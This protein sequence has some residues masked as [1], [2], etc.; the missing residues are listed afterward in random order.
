V[1][2]GGGSAITTGSNPPSD[3]D[4]AHG[5]Q[6]IRPW[7]SRPA[8]STIEAVPPVSNR[9]SLTFLGG[10]G[11]VT[12]SRF[13]V[14]S[15]AAKVLIDCGLYQGVKELRLRNWAPFPVAPSTLDAVVLTHAHVDHSGYLPRLVADGFD[16]PVYATPGTTELARIVL[17]DSGHL[18][19][20]DAAFANRRGFSKHRPP[21]PLFTEAD[22]RT[23]CGLLHT[24]E[25]GHRHD[26]AP[27][28][29][30]T[31]RAA[32]HI[33]GSAIVEL[34]LADDV[35]VAFSGDLGRPCHPLL[36]PPTPLGAVDALVIESTYGNRVHEDASA[37][38]GL[39]SVIERT[40][41][42]GG[43]VVIPA[44]AVDRTEIVLF[45]LARLMTEGCIPSLPVFVD[46]PMA[47]ASLA[48]YRRAVS[49]QWAEL[50][51]NVCADADDPFDTGTLEEAHDVEQSIAIDQMRYP[52]IVVSAAGMAT[53]GRILHHLAARLPDPRNAIVLVGFQAEGTRGRQ[54]A[55]GARHIKIFGEYLPARAEVIELPALSVH[56]DAGELVEWVAAS[57]TP[58]NVVYTV[59]GEPDAAAALCAALS[60]RIDRPAVAP[61]YLE[62]VA[63][64][65]T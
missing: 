3:I 1:S 54:L 16:G 7:S 61:R 17:P 63:L 35:T 47:L 45:H 55:E 27:G 22:A 26:V 43:T 29:C 18:Q 57:A 28:V 14:E 58:P 62:R 42:R 44:F 2:L 53:G 34:R 65:S 24:I 13:L 8:R 60:D 30:V 12:G 4:D 41:R 64:R 48:V 33:L 9:P 38:D 5:R 20:E 49:E 10:T 21:L 11:T 36:L 15:G 51:P 39:A 52:S 6:D 32:G 40:A 23:A 46:S 50:R 31:L 19:E 25:Y 37:L 59:H 56:A